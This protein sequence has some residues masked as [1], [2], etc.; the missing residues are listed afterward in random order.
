MYARTQTHMRTIHF[1][2]CPVQCARVLAWQPKR[3]GCAA[4]CQKVGACRRVPKGMRG[5]LVPCRRGVDKRTPWP[6]LRKITG[7]AANSAG[8]HA[9]ID[10]SSVIS[11]Y[12]ECMHDKNPRSPPS[13]QTAVMI[14]I[15]IKPMLLD[16]R[17][18]AHADRTVCMFTVVIHGHVK[19]Q[20]SEQAPGAKHH[21][22]KALLVGWGRAC[23]CSHGLGPRPRTGGQIRRVM[24]AL[25]E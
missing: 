22:P 8:C 2:G 16:G 13:G 11:T 7:L 19:M 24:S 25:G 1:N 12:T 4:A 21:A 14:A 6:R 15:R 18:A 20:V 9:G 23:T 17:A 3:Q 5:S 10:H